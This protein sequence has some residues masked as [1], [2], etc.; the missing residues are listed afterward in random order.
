M[1]GSYTI[2]L[3]LFS[4]LNSSVT[5]FE[6]WAE[7][8]QFGATHTISSAGTS[9]SVSIPYGGALPSSLEFR[10]NDTDTDTGTI[11]QIE[12]RSVKINDKY[13]NVANYLSADTLNDGQTSTVD[14]SGAD[15][16]FDDSEP[17]GSEF[18][19]GATQT[20]TTGADK[21]RGY[22]GTS[23]EVFDLLDGNDNAA[24][25]SGD[26]K[27]NGNDGRDTIRGGAGN[28]LIA[29]GADNDRLY[30]QDGNDKIY[31]GTG[32]DMLFGN[33]GADE[34]FG[35]DGNDSLSGHDGDDIL[36]GGTGADR[37]SGGNDNDYLFGGADNDQLVG[38]N[39]D[40][41]LDGGDGDDLAYGGLGNDFINGGDGADTL[42]GNAGDDII[43]GD[44]G[45]D[46]ILGREDNDTLFG[47]AG[48]DYIL[49]GIGDDTVNGGGD[50]DRIVGGEVRLIN[51]NNQVSYDPTQDGGG[52]VTQFNGGFML[53]G[54]NWKKIVS[55]FTITA[56]TV[57]EFDFKST[58]EAEVSGIG[59]DTDDSISSATTFELYGTQGWGI[60][61]F[62][63]Y[64]G[65]GEWTHY[66]I[67]VGS[68]F[69]GNF[70][71]LIFANDDDGNQPANG[72]D[73]NAFFA[74]IIIY[75][76]TLSD[77]IDNL[78]GGDG[79]D[80]ILGNKGV[81]TLNGGAG[82]D[83]I[84]GNDG[85]DIINGDA[86]ADT[87]H[88][89]AGADILNGGTGNDEIYGNDGDDVIILDANND[90]ING[91]AG[92]D[93]IDASSHTAYVTVDLSVLTGQVTR[94]GTDTISNVENLIGTNF[95]DTLGGDSGVN[96]I[97]GGTGSDRIYGNGGA[98][99]LYGEAGN[100]DF[101]VE[102]TEAYDTLFDGGADYD[103]IQ[104]DADSY[105]N[106]AS[107]FTDVERVDMNG[108]DAYALINDGLDFSGMIVTARGDIFGDIGNETISGTES[109]DDIFGLD[110]NDIINGNAGND[111]LYGGDG[112]DTINGGAGNDSI[113]GEIG[114][115]ILNGDDGADNFYYGGTEAAGDTVDGGAGSDDIYLSSNI[116][117][118]STTTFTN[119]ERVVFSGFTATAVTNDS[120]SF[121]GMTAS[122]TSRL[123]GQ[124][125]NETITGTEST[126][127]FYGG[128][129]ADILNGGAGNDDFHVAGNESLGDQ[130]D[131]GAGTDDEIRLSADAYFNSAN[132]FVNMEQ[133]VFNGFDAY[134]TAGSTVDFSDM[135]RSSTG[136]IIGDTGNETITG[137]GNAD[138]IYGL[139]G[140]DTL[141][142]G[143]GS[144]FLYGGD[145]ND[146]ING[147]A[148]NDQIYGGL[149]AD[150]LNGDAGN[151]DFR[152]GGNEALG[153]T[154]DG[155]ADYDE[156]VLTAD[157]FLD[158]TTTF[159]NMERV[160]FG[161]F[162]I[163]ANTGTGFDLS[164]MV[165]NGN[166]FLYGQAGSENITG[167]ESDDN[168]YGLEGADILNGSAGNDN[169]YVSGTESAGDQYDGGA[170]TDD[171]IILLADSY[172]NSANSFLNIEQVVFAGFDMLIESGAT[173]DFTG[174]DRSG[175]GRIMGA[176]GNETITGM[177]N[178]DIVHGLGGADVINTAAGND[179][180]YIGGNEAAGDSING[181]TG[182]DDLWLSS[183]A[184]L[185]FTTTITNMERVVFNGFTITANTGT[186][187]NLSGMTISGTSLLYGQGGSE[188]I[189]GTESNDDFYGGL[190]ADILNGGGAND[191]FFVAGAEAL[192]D[193]Y[194]GGAGTD[195][196]R[197]T[198]DTTFNAA[199]SFTS[200]NAIVNGGFSMNL[201]AGE[202]INFSGM[203]R[204]GAGFAVGTASNETYIGFENADA[205]RGMSGADTISTGNGNDSIY[206][207][208][209]DSLGDILDGGAGTDYLRL[210][211][212]SYFNSANTFTNMETVI[213]G[214]F[215]M[216]VDSG[217]TV[218]LSGL[219]RSGTGQIHGSAGNEDI[220][221]MNNNDIMYGF[222]GDDI[223]RGGNGNDDL[224]GGADNDTLYD[225]DGLDDLYGEAGADTF[226]FENATAFNDIDRVRDFSLA[227]NDAIDIK[228]LLSG[229]TFGV[230]DLTDFVQILD[231]GSRSDIYV[232]TAGTGTFVTTDRVATLYSITGITDEVA[233]ETS[234]HLITH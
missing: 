220:T 168:I 17:A 70:S 5:G 10:F 171:E 115:D 193:I 66:K 203:N 8:S 144:D 26:D 55:N 173:V 59:F 31:G 46:L 130:Y 106:L 123:Y 147:G 83:N 110:G 43:H 19:T 212:D 185:D 210:E 29:G 11:D 180:I 30:G 166:S 136:N 206:V 114:A 44:D 93:V 80:Q 137:M 101:Y 128:L 141:N 218:D 104:F 58:I 200:I 150:I 121:A 95:N 135:V 116:F 40:D 63:N 124:A 117:L 178:G 60:Q 12:I 108:H 62:N 102:G 179:D 140:N 129:G 186:G 77:D 159:T 230:D 134:V 120:F 69:T 98:D 45:N 113:Y 232:D 72:T 1:A 97:T 7:G 96:V 32:N 109:T 192:G 197:M 75:E 126:D 155:G 199:N 163:T 175:T 181:G 207:S 112:N 153:D 53:D 229:Y 213:F 209:T 208:G 170:G 201:A 133:F 154:V 4:L 50:N 167:T 38:G 194:D 111:F 233:L 221:G 73:G 204:S 52:T 22:N 87:L 33:N 145:G 64:D 196:V 71:S 82:D 91:G 174:I 57:L 202:T 122:G 215:N 183:N 172:F 49:A 148:N 211:A 127:A 79:D 219:L 143:V 169:F 157:L 3:E 48:D 231:N 25:G 74:N 37:L 15:F 41:T 158:L 214:G 139:G 217:A 224:Y 188:T 81:D 90:I 9:I 162:T 34:L 125:G 151:D 24:L 228:D 146:T 222:A 89:G 195:Y 28:D 191:D 16:I 160:V 14:V 84:S 119:M 20:F 88:G 161:G 165:R 76:D 118:D 234:G 42:V 105:F 152:Y 39:G 68:Y 65:S 132:S 216:I 78:N 2:E 6:I 86:G 131:G 138:T 94:L 223:L 67:D 107:T 103:E 226:V 61:A 21:Y 164:G 205:V 18:T 23:D 27:V 54:N 92:I 13:V 184:F 182:S 190:G 85:D 177:D 187:F 142:G 99:L 100:D 189:T 56:N 198:A 225:G 227:E 51:T 36:V 149:G 35:G 176:A 47:G 156:L